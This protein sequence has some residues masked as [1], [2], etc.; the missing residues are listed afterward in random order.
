MCDQYL[1]DV[2]KML[3]FFLPLFL[4]AHF[5]PKPSHSDAGGREAHSAREHRNRGRRRGREEALKEGG[6]WPASLFS[7][8]SY[9]FFN[10]GTALYF[11]HGMI[12]SQAGI[13]ILEAAPQ[14]TL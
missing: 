7:V 2:Y 4:Q 6:F 9:L 3:I 1:P 5:S 10:L 12:L 14:L 11:Q 8:C 13:L